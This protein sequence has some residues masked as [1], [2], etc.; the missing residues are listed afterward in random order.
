MLVA[1]GVAGLQLIRYV[2]PGREGLQELVN[3]LVMTFII[4]LFCEIVPKTVFRA[5]ADTLALKSVPLL[6]ISSVFLRPVVSGVTRIS[7]LVVNLA[8]EEDKDEK[9][10]VMREELKL[11]AK[12]GQEEGALK[13]AQL[14]MIQSLLDLEARSV[15]KVMAP[16][17]EVVGVPEGTLVEQFLES[18][19]ESGYSRI[20]VYAER[21]DHI[22]GV[23]NILD[24]IYADDPAPT[25][26]PYIRKDILHVPESK[27]LFSLLRELSRS[28]NPM[29]LVVDEYGGVVGLVTIEDI[30]E[31]IMGDI[32]DER[33]RDED[34]AV[35]KISDRI[36]DCE[37]KTEIHVLNRDYNLSIPEGDYNTIA[38]YV[39]DRMQKIPRQGESFVSQNLRIL[40][41]DADAKS[42]HRV[43][44]MKK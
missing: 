21:I 28:R 16:L 23:I 3:T 12:M 4:L 18:V 8:K 30:V 19:S 40:V 17:V 22:V 43:R 1:A 41:L 42:V 36:L 6:F 39:V 31:E 10:R 32:R 27:R 34:L 35:Q 26:D 20:P 13:K 11:L 33:D 24:V 44:I 7:N 9:S 25:I 15:E 14:R 5:K 38:G 2:F 37:G 29:A